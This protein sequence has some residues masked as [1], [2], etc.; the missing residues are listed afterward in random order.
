MGASFM[1][2]AGL[3]DWVATDDDAYVATAVAK[4]RDRQ[5]LLQIKRQ[6]RERQLASPAWDVTRHTRNME[7]A[8][9]AMA[10][11]CMDS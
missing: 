3:D 7:D 1:R 8:L 11:S 5:A 2:A 9:A 4:G 6:M 10:R